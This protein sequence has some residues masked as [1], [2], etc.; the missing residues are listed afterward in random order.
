MTWHSLQAIYAWSRL[1]KPH[2]ES[3]FQG[4]ICQA[5][6]D[7]YSAS[8]VT[9]PQVFIW[10]HWPSYHVG[11]ALRSR[12]GQTAQDRSHSLRAGPISCNDKLKKWHSPLAFPSYNG[13]RQLFFTSSDQ[14]PR[15]GGRAG[16][17]PLCGLKAVITRATRCYYAILSLASFQSGKRLSLSK[18]DPRLA[19][20]HPSMSEAGKSAANPRII[21][22]RH[23]YWESLGFPHF[24]LRF[25]ITFHIA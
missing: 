13:E 19:H 20:L 9:P 18:F 24:C 17:R 22:A 7:T 1:H 6:L 3:F 16:S 10:Q 14:A 23:H 8:P 11:G 15:G 21:L 4:Q 12:V 5:T 25:A 2:A